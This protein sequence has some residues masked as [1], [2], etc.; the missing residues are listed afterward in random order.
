MF[1]FCSS[2]TTALMQAYR[3]NELIILILFNNAH[4]LIIIVNTTF[5]ITTL[6]ACETSLQVL[7]DKTVT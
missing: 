5:A 6:F 7:T 1:I 3:V 2:G 4:Y